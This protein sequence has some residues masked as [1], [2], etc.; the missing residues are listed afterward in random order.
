MIWN[1]MQYMDYLNMDQLEYY[2]HL[3][4][5]IHY[6]DNNNFQLYLYID[7][8]FYMVQFLINIHL[9]LQNNREVL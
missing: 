2:N 7:H 8:Y 4:D 1:L 3:L 6:I 5:N 9:Y